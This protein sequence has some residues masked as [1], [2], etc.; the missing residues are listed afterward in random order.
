MA[1]AIGGTRLPRLRTRRVRRSAGLS[2]VVAGLTLLGSVAYQLWGTGI[3]T[4]RAQ[5]E[6]RRQ[7]AAHGLPAHPIPGGAAGFIRISRIHL[8]M[9]FVQGAGLDALAR[10]PGHYPLTPMPGQGGNVAIAGHRTTYL[11]PFWALNL[12]RPG[13]RIVLRT[14]AGTFVYRVVWQR[15]V[16][17]DD[18]SVIAPTPVPSLTLTTCNPRFDSW[19]RLVVRAVQV[20][21]PSPTR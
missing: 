18:W 4:S 13:D 9:A 1:G 8:D 11:H 20:S 12:V 10:G 21:A 19:Q 5:A 14:R 16:A 15:A 2:L 6:I 7:V 3:Q 17:P